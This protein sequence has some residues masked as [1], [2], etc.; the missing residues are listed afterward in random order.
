MTE[1]KTIDIKGKE[2][3]EVNERIRYFREEYPEWSIVT[4]WLSVDVEHGIC[5]AKVLD[6]RRSVRA[7]GTAMELQGNG[8]INKF[9]HVENCETSAV[10][11]A[12][13]IMGIG[14]DTSVAS[15]EEVANAVKNQTSGKEPARPNNEKFIKA[16]RDLGYQVN[17][18]NDIVKKR[19]FNSITQVHDREVQAEIYTDLKAWK[20]EQI[21]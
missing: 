21:L 3:V 18:L 6:E 19:G 15:Y 12:L 13:G 11:R 9:S 8:F 14:I 17:E 7:T 5:V 20:E 2:Y 10:G 16:C 1:L 4:E